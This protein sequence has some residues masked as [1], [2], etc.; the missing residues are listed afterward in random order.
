MLVLHLCAVLSLSRSIVYSM[1]IDS[2]AANLLGAGGSSDA[3]LLSVSVLLRPVLLSLLAA[4][5]W[6]RITLGHSP[7]LGRFD[8]RLIAA[9]V[10]V[11]AA[12]SATIYGLAQVS[13]RTACALLLVFWSALVLSASVAFISLGISVWSARVLARRAQQSSASPRAAGK[14]TP[15]DFQ[16]VPRP[17]VLGASQYDKLAW[18]R[19]AG[20]MTEFG[21]LKASQEELDT[22]GRRRSEVDGGFPKA[23][24]PRHQAATGL[25]INTHG[26][27]ASAVPSSMDAYGFDTARDEAGSRQA[28][29]HLLVPVGPNSMRGSANSRRPS[30][31]S[32]I[33]VAISQR[34]ASAGAGTHPQGDHAGAAPTAATSELATTGFYHHWAAQSSGD[35]LLPADDRGAFGQTQ[36]SSPPPPSPSLSAFI[37]DRLRSPEKGGD[38]SYLDLDASYH[39]VG[40]TRGRRSAGSAKSFAG[41]PVPHTYTQFDGT[42]GTSSGSPDASRSLTAADTPARSM[43]PVSFAAPPST[44]RSGTR[45]RMRTALETHEPGYVT[46]RSLRSFL[47]GGVPPRIEHCV[48]GGGEDLLGAS[49]AVWAAIE[50]AH[51]AEARMLNKGAVS[52][53]HADDQERLSEAEARRALV[54]IGGYLAGVLLPFVSSEPR[55]S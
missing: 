36:R 13:P 49:G 54:R 37:D 9:A 15:F 24:L 16:P 3:A 55:V 35:A 11:A 34:R 48:Q 52:A 29:P 5:S 44:S 46:V 20:A 10:F 45:S 51:A 1:K 38:I 7:A 12:L 4:S 39:P 28:L 19:S 23:A 42:F 22:F 53:L 8:H 18:P 32:R 41:A 31:S 47:S 21:A 6:S 40:A 43:T 14:R 30:G 33:P 2:L 26:T 50:A 25:T 17:L 27:G